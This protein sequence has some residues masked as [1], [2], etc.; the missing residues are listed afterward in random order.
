MDEKNVL[1][2]PEFLWRQLSRTETIDGPI[3]RQRAEGESHILL[4]EKNWTKKM[5]R[6]FLKSS[7]ESCPELKSYG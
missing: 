3:L 7:G 4:N 1:N 5:S 2:I 6:P